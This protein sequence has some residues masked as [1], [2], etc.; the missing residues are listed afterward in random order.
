MLKTGSSS[1]RRQAVSQFLAPVSG[2][3]DLA[4]LT[5]R[6][7]TLQGAGSQP[8]CP[9]GHG[10][11]H[12][13]GGMHLCVSECVMSV[14]GPTGSRHQTNPLLAS[15]PISGRRPGDASTCKAMPASARGRFGF[16]PLPM[17]V[18]GD[19]C[20]PGWEA[21]VQALLRASLGSCRKEVNCTYIV[22]CVRAVLHKC[23]QETCQRRAKLSYK[24]CFASATGH[25][26]ISGWM[27]LPAPRDGPS[28]GRQVTVQ[29][30]CTLFSD[31][32]PEGNAL[33]LWGSP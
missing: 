17:G 3:T 4:R 23:S 6:L 19:L 9:D 12:A 18:L 15:R 5:Y 30:Q 20:L 14:P 29:V 31:F 2:V 24:A 16:S 21:C 33:L 26:V 8:S 32:G 25:R 28:K 22:F 13:P 27:Q 1:V 10:G 11:T 7:N